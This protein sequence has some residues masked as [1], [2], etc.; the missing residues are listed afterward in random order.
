MNRLKDDSTV[1]PGGV[2]PYVNPE[3]GYRIESHAFGVLEDKVK[4]YRKA[5]H[6]PIGSNF[7]Q[8][9][10][11]IV[12]QNLHPDCCFEYEPPSP[13]QRAKQAAFALINWAKQGFKV[14][15]EEEINTIRAICEVCPFYSGKSGLF[16]IACGACGCGGLKLAMEGTKCPKGKWT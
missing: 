6:Y 3:D 1:P 12:C 13:A 7:H 14:R 2:F 8:D 9:F 10:E 15:S 4:S 11:K 16:K 5:N